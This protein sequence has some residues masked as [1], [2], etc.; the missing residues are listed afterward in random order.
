V[1]DRSGLIGEFLSSVEDRA[2]FPWINMQAV[3]TGYTSFFNV[4]ICPPM[5]SM[6]AG[7]EFDPD[8]K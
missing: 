5:A 7:V 8:P 6:W 3:G 4:G 1:E 2:R